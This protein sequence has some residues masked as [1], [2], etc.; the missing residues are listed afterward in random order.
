MLLLLS[1]PH[2]PAEPPP[3][4]NFLYINDELH[5][6]DYFEEDPDRLHAHYLER[7]S[8]VHSL[9]TAWLCMGV[10]G[11]VNN[12]VVACVFTR[13]KMRSPVNFLLAAI[14]VFDLLTLSSETL[15]LVLE[16]SVSH[17]EGCTNRFNCANNLTVYRCISKSMFL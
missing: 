5:Y 7:I 16:M 12:V 10:L 11:I 14:A 6:Y 13:A 2:E 17:E 3:T 9:N 15:L 4:N 8:R 1:L